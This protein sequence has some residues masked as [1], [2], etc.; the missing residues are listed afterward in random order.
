MEEAYWGRSPF[1]GKPPNVQAKQRVQEADGQR[2]EEREIL[3]IHA[4]KVIFQKR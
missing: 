1:L 3:G 2:A 4:V